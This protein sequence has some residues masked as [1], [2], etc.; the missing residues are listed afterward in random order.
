MDVGT[1]FSRSPEARA[2]VILAGLGHI[3]VHAAVPLKYNFSATAI[4]GYQS[5][6][7][8]SVYN[9]VQGYGFDFGF[10]SAVTYTAA[11]DGIEGKKSVKDPTLANWTGDPFYLPAQQAF[12][13]SVEVPRG[14]YQVTITMGNKDSAV[15]ATIRAEQRRLMIESWQVPAGQSQTRTIDVNRRGDTIAGGSTMIGITTR[16]Q[17]YVDLDGRLTIEFNGNRPVVQQLVIAPVDTDITVYLAGNSTVVDQP[18]EPWST[19]GENFPRFFRSGVTISDQAESGLTLASFVAQRRLTNIASTLKAGDYVFVEFGHNDMKDTTPTL[20]QSMNAWKTN[21][22]S[23]ISTVKGKGAT[24]VLVSPTARLSFSGTTAVNTRMGYTDSMRSI[25]KEQGVAFLDL[26]GLSTTFIEALGPSNAAKAYTHFI[27]NT[28]PGQTAALADNTHWNDYGGYE[29]A[30]A[31]ATAVKTQSANF[32]FAKCLSDDYVDF[33]PATPDVY[34]SFQLPFS[35]FMGAFTPPDSAVTTRLS[36]QAYARSG[37]RIASTSF[38]DGILSLTVNGSDAGLEARVVAMEGEHVASGFLHG[39]S[40]IQIPAL[41]GFSHRI[42]V[43]EIV[44]DGVIVDEQ[45]VLP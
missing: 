33:S 17:T 2:I 41:H 11:K 12:F 44:R 25:A 37:I 6:T 3:G 1:W 20:L 34:G 8:K 35:P 23:F 7:P 16:E 32:T 22:V 43:V 21:M 42:Y 28:V 29:L 15:T 38:R 10:D 31:M 14:N 5:I 18:Q 30:K 39:Q 36:P 45:K 24:P 26:N 13:F 4:V 27:A 40:E 9:T 19:W